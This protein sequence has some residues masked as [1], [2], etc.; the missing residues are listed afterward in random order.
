[1]KILP[2][3]LL[4]L[5][6][7]F[8]KR[9]D[10]QGCL[11]LTINSTTVTAA[12]CPSGGGITVSATGTSL[13]FQ[14]ISG[15]TGYLTASN[16]TG[17]FNSLAAGDYV[18][19]VKDGCGVVVNVSKTVPDTYPAFTVSN[20]TTSN[21]CTSGN[22]GGTITGTVSGGKPPYQYDIV[23]VAVSPVYSAN[24][25]STSYSKAFAA[26]GSYR[27]YAKDACGEVR[28][29]DIDLEPSQPAPVNLWWEDLSLDRPCAETMD[30]LSTITW[31]LHFL[32]Q[33]GTGISF[34]NLI[35]STYQIYKPSPANSI[36]F[37]APNAGCTVTQGALLVSGT[38]TAGMI[39][40]G[41][42]MTLP[43]AVPQEDL[44]LVFKTKCG[45]TFKYCYNFNQG[46]P[47]TPS[48]VVDLVQ[49]ACGA[50]W[51]SQTIY[52]RTR[53][54]DFMTYPITFLLT[55]NGGT[56]V[57]NST[58]T[59]TNLVPNNFPATVKL[60]DACGRVVTKALPRPVQGSALSAIAEP[61]WSFTCTNTRGTSTAVIRVTGGDLPGLEQATN[62]TITGGTATAIP[63]I[64]QFYN[65]LPGYYASNL[66]PGYAYK[67]L[68]TNLCN[69]KDSILF[70]VPADNWTQPTLDWNLTASAAA[71]CGQNKSTITA[72]ANFTG[73]NTL[74]YYL[75]NL[76]AP[77]SILASNTTGIFT[78][79][80]PGNYKVKFIA[81]LSNGICSGADIADSINMTVISDSV[82]QS[83]T[84]KTITTCEAA[85]GTQYNYG[86]AIVEVNGSAPFT[87]EI[88][89]TSLIGTGVTEIWNTS[90]TNN[91]SST[92]TWDIPLAGDSSSTIY[93]LRC[94]DKCGN[95]VTT[96]ASLQPLSPPQL[97]TSMNPCIGSPDY[98]LR[99]AQYAG[100]FS[101]RWVKLPDTVTTLSNLN[102]LSFPG[103]YS[104]VNDGSYR[105][106]IALTG[107]V[108][109]TRNVNISSANCGRP[110]PVKLISFTGKHEKG[111][112]YLNWQT[113]NEAG[114]KNYIVEKSLNGIDFTPL[115]TVAA[116]NNLSG[117]AAYSSTDY[118]RNSN[119]GVVLYRLKLVDKDGKFSY[120]NIIRISPE[121]KAGTLVVFPNPVISNISFSFT[122]N[123]NGTAA[124]TIFDKTG[125]TVFMN[126]IK[127]SKGDNTLIL[128]ETKHLPAGTYIIQLTAPSQ[129]ANARLVKL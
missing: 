100:S 51:N 104:S 29:Y 42:E 124:I 83:I 59:F 96:Q 57:T 33:N 88:I 123:M 7:F 18:I 1:M 11:T 122:S 68:I 28:T 14:I 92:F 87:Y 66:L 77:N 79:V 99:I 46:N 105:C 27:V 112:V 73:T 75:Y 90:S 22:T 50:T 81:T 109:R 20:A 63:T 34:N 38:V 3:L 58:G 56:T 78:D 108:Q 60:T 98:T 129:T 102:T 12:S 35:G 15:P 53:W 2:L 101:Y 47:V 10:A 17:V 70:T 126:T 44:I 93:T 52:I 31:K 4:T 125:R 118:L 69:E 64:S 25:A 114:M 40:P 5:L 21:V 110:V 32:D 19:E 26:F 13:T 91:F 116:M 30:G 23:P 120:S 76:T 72:S 113:E 41:D 117:S 49:Q 106:Y 97:Q 80:S 121:S 84:R 128:P 103:P 45:E 89:R 39:I 62:V 71:L 24:T 86:K 65:D 127:F 67:I 55:K 8:S 61:E 9:L 119:A 82:G 54:V 74:N 85:N 6:S 37:S 43:I 94:T 16:H 95:K 36:T 48:V 107:C 111:W 115:N